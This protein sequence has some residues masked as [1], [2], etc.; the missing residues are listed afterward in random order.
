[1]KNGE[2]MEIQNSKNS[3]KDVLYLALCEVAVA[4]LIVLGYLLFGKMGW[5]VVTGAILG[6]LVTVANFFILSV[7]VNKA[8]N[9]YLALRGDREMTDEE[10]A[11]FSKKHG[12]MVRNAVTKSYMLRTALM[13]GALVL[14]FISKWFDPVATLIPLLMYKPLI[15]VVQLIKQKRGE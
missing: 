5:T 13:V 8:I 10:A 3:Y 11:E 4:V 14:A 6:G 2:K 9:D 7:G 12:L 1:M 15:Y